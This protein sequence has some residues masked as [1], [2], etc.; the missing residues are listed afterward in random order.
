MAVAGLLHKVNDPIGSAVRYGL[1][2]TSTLID[3]QLNW[4][5]R[6]GVHAGPVVA[7]VVGRERHQFDIRGDTV[8]VAARLVSMSAPEARES[9][10]DTGRDPERQQKLREH[11]FAVAGM[12]PVE[13]DAL[14]ERVLETLRPSEVNVERLPVSADRRQLST[15]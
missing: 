4:E 5:V 13:F 11:I 15:D 14:Y 2:M 8:N 3:A 6:M 9:D 7:G 10:R 12:G 1:E